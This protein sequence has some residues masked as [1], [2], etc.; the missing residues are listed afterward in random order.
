MTLVN[1]NYT[2]SAI[3]VISM[4]MIILCHLFGEYNQSAISNIFRIGVQIFLFISGYLHANMK[5]V[6]SGKEYFA[7]IRKK[8]LRINV[9]V[10]IFVICVIAILL[11]QGQK[12]DIVRGLLI[13]GLDMRGIDSTLGWLYF[14]EPIIRGL[15]S[16]WYLTPLMI[17]Y[18]LLPLMQ[19]VFKN[20]TSK[21]AIRIAIV[22][23]LGVLVLN[24]AQLALIDY[25][26]FLFGLLTAKYKWRINGVIRYAG[27]TAVM[28]ILMLL[29]F[30]SD[31]TTLLFPGIMSAQKL[32]FSIWV[33]AT[34]EKI[35]NNCG[36]INGYVRKSKLLLKLD[37]MSYYVYIVH[38]CFL[39]GPFYMLTLSNNKAVAISGF[40]IATF[41]ASVV[42]MWLDH[43]AVSLIKKK[44]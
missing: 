41:I 32:V 3:R 9:P 7:F 8:F 44:A 40:L 39:A 29:R 30:Y 42:L 26:I 43:M 10:Y 31:N 33:L 1:R 25:Y 38:Q 27:L 28:A 16:L 34:F 36:F 11:A 37:N 18:V 22:L 14:E 4:F 12:V 20:V 21:S 17:C 6:N 23:F 13:Y 35:I 15:S 19:R 2:I 5:P 24:F